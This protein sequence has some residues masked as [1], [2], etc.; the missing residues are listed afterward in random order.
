MYGSGYYQFKL[1]LVSFLV[2]NAFTW[3]TCKQHEFLTFVFRYLFL[4]IMA[5]RIDMLF[6]CPLVTS[7]HT[8]FSCKTW[9]SVLR[10]MN[11]FY[12]IIFVAGLSLVFSY[13]MPPM[14][15]YSMVISTLY[16]SALSQLYYFVMIVFAFIMYRH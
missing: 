9:C 6:I 16:N 12:Y 8:F 4:T 13:G 15:L 1:L 14:C 5:H 2:K 10:E 11:G 7:W 3:F